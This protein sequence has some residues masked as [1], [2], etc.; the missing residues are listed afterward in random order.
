VELFIEP[1]NLASI[2]VAQSC[3]YREEALLSHH[4]EIGGR[5]RDM[6]RYAA[7][8]PTCTGPAGRPGPDGGDPWKSHPIE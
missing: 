8:R 2:A 5:L 4:T 3:G 7:E 1:T 6:V